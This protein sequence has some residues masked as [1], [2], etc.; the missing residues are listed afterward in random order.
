VDFSGGYS[1]FTTSGQ[2]ILSSPGANFSLI[3]LGNLPGGN[4][5][6]SNVSNGSFIGGHFQDTVGVVV[7]GTGTN[8]DTLVTNLNNGLGGGNNK[9][10]I[11]SRYQIN[12]ETQIDFKTKATNPTS[13]DWTDRN[14]ITDFDAIVPDCTDIK[15][16]NNILST[17]KLGNITPIGNVYLK[18]QSGKTL[19]LYLQ[20]LRSGVQNFTGDTGFSNTIVHLSLRSAATVSGQVLGNISYVYDL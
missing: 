3:N 17:L 4:I 1:N 7:M 12:R 16:G 8:C 20:D 13:L 11:T 2:E 19:N 9:K 6:G 10:A 14:D 18:G 15:F 5:S